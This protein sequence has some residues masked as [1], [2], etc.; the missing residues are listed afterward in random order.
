MKARDRAFT[1]IELLVVIAIIAI[2]ASMLLPA[3]TKAREKARGSVCMSNLKQQ[4]M[5]VMFYSDE[6]VDWTPYAVNNVSNGSAADIVGPT[7]HFLDLS[8]F[9]LLRVY[10]TEPNAVEGSGAWSDYFAANTTYDGS[11]WVLKSSSP[12]HCPTRRDL[13]VQDAYH[14]LDTGDA[15]LYYP[16]YVANGWSEPPDGI[17][18][19]PSKVVSFTNPAALML[20]MDGRGYRFNCTQ[21]A[22]PGTTYVARH[23]LGT[24]MVM[25]DGH[26]QNR[27][28]SL[29]D[30]ATERSLYHITP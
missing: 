23:S 30:L 10:L 27:K 2:L 18:P 21:P 3:L 22:A 6:A 15:S 19:F 5:A 17:R 9:T 16:A 20:I 14:L 4:G 24:N 8:W 26:V 13:E 11:K 12:Y 29:P 7:A 25:G 28:G 1:L